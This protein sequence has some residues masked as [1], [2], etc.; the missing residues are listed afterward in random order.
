M[1]GKEVVVS[2]VKDILSDSDDK[3]LGYFLVSMS[4]SDVEQYF[5]DELKEKFDRLSLEKQ[6][7]FCSWLMDQMAEMFEESPEYGFRELF[8]A[9]LD[10]LTEDE[11][12]EAMENDDKCV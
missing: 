7:A 12:K 11:I 5:P 8:D 1:T 2:V 3:V 6:K 9:T 4:V 10:M